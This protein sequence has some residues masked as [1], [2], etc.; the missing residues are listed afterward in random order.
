[1]FTVVSLTAILSILFILSKNF[2]HAG[3]SSS[4]VATKTVLA[5]KCQL[6]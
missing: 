6:C 1:M 4:T 2:C 3:A 5:T